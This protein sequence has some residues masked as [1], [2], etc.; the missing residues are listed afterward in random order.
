[1]RKFYASRVNDATFFRAERMTVV[2]RRSRMSLWS[3]VALRSLAM[4]RLLLCGLVT[5]AIFANAAP[6]RAQISYVQ[7][8][9]NGSV[10]LHQMNADGSGDVAIALPFSTF[11]F[12]TWSRNGARLAITASD[13]ASPNQR[14]Q[15]VFTIDAA[16]GGIGAVTFINDFFSP[17]GNVIYTY[18]YHKA[19]S[20]D[21]SAMAVFSQVR[22]GGDAGT[23]T[24]TPVLEIYP[25]NGGAEPLQVHVDKGMN[26]KHHGGEG[27]DWSPAQNVLV[28][29]VQSSAPFLS[30]GG[31]GET[32]ALVLMDPV[33]GASVQGRYRQLTF[34]RADGSAG[35]GATPYL[36]GEH[37]YMPKFSPNGVGVAFVRSFQNFFLLNSATPEPDVQ[38]LH[39]VNVQTG[40]DTPVLQLPAGLYVTGLDWSPDGSKLIFDA[41]QQLP[42]P[43]GPQQQIA[44]QTDEIFI[45]NVDGSGLQKL[46]SGGAGTPSWRANVPQPPATLG[47]IST[48]LRVGSGDDALIGGFIVTGSAPKTVII[49]ALGPSL[50]AAGVAGALSDPVLELHQGDGIVATND[51]WQQASNVSAIPNGFAPP[52]GREAV[53]VTTLNPGSYTAIVRGAQGQTGVGLIEAYDLSGGGGS[54][55]ANISTRGGVGGGDDVLIGGFIAVGG[56]GGSA[57]VIIRALGPSLGNGGVA[58]A[59][60]DPSL[61]L[62]DGNGTTVRTN[63][64]WQESQAGEIQQTG[65]PPSDAREPAILATLP[66]GNYTAVVRGQGGSTGVSLV[67]VYNLQ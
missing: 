46:R 6:L 47:N 18:P 44:P 42:G 55:L 59:L 10:Q 57:K 52:D 40:A 60:Q 31:P 63:N 27:V 17:T 13:P 50:G 12:P 24:T 58:G 2:R 65:I 37:D 43:L 30:G 15:N 32:T 33:A 23:N 54:Q 16:T 56:P 25:T 64:G 39:I 22:Y 66:P 35:L 41:G 21:G 48:R 5:A 34:P 7:L 62:V 26:G 45:V 61:E 29:P 11:E 67:E 3:R 38:S 1:M 53:I 9:P 51:N 4:K 36:W 8:Q 28:L 14:G 20:P 19:F 49:R